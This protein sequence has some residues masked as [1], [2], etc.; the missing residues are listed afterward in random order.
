MLW[1]W[2]FNYHYYYYNLY[3]NVY[4]EGYA[5]RRVYE[6]F[7]NVWY[8]R[9]LVKV[10]FFSFLT[11]V[12]LKTPVFHLTCLDLAVVMMLFFF[13]QFRWVSKDSFILIYLFSLP[14]CITLAF[15][16]KYALDD[17]FSGRN[18][19]VKSV[20]AHK[21]TVLRCMERI[22]V[23]L[24]A[25][26][27]LRLTHHTQSLRQDLDHVGWLRRFSWQPCLLLPDYPW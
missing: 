9:P 16:S 21:I 23:V 13:T 20:S 6:E 7:K 1:H 22:K 18:C 4:K 5:M 12:A 8:W 24:L 14:V 17:T 27:L 15:L 11:V 3:K 10:S 26:F 25:A 2:S 19:T